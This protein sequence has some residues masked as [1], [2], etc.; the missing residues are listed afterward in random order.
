[1]F[2]F[3][4]LVAHSQG[5]WSV[6]NRLK[7]WC[8]FRVSVCNC[9][10]SSLRNIWS[11]GLCRLFLCVFVSMCVCMCL[12]VRARKPCLCVCVCMCMRVSHV[13]VCMCVRVSRVC[14]CMC[15]RVSRVCV[16]VYVSVCACAWAMSVCVCACKWAVSVCHTFLFFE[17]ILKSIC[18][19]CVLALERTQ[20]SYELTRVQLVLLGVIF[21]WK[22]T[23]KQ[24]ASSN[25]IF[26]F[27]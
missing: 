24:F 16:C 12:Y 8:N 4:G 23:V 19:D 20:K 2:Y 15:V 3:F 10:D 9:V 7:N 22:M 27:C 26:L 18:I 13:C 11:F 21:V 17:T 25:N 6:Q 14:V 5:C 1:M